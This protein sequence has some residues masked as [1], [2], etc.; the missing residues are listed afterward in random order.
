[1]IRFNA[2]YY[3]KTESA[4]VAAAL[5]GEDFLP[6]AKAH[7]SR[8]YGTNSLFL[9]SSGGTALDLLLC[10]LDLPQGQRAILPSFTFP[11]DANAVLRAGL[12]PLFADIDA[13]NTL[14]IGDVS[15]KITP[16]TACV[17]PTH[18]GGASVDMDTLKS[19]I[20][21]A[22]LIEDAALSF[23]AS[24]KNRPLGTVGDMGIVSFHRTKN[25]SSEEGGM[26]IVNHADAALLEKIQT[27]YDNGTD[28]QAFLR[29]DVPAYTWQSSGMN[30][31]MSN[32]SAAVLCAQL[33]KADE[34]ACRR[35]AVYDAYL[36]A[37]KHT[38]GITLP[39]VPAY[40]T[41]NHHVFY[42][43]L[44]DAQ[45]RDR[46]LRQLNERGIGACFHYMPLHTSAMGQR[47]GC[48]PADLPVTVDISARILRLPLHACMTPRDAEYAAT[49]LK[50]V[51]CGQ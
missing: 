30:G 26:L 18:Y 51:L 27:I 44:N 10:A 39:H 36:A 34:I 4:N 23:G 49:A 7:L 17:I 22:L 40:N 45:I 50:E 29:G 15:A 3:D 11:S 25:I 48:R 28:K 47:L 43:L 32:L 6:Q 21:N 46:V 8:I 33:D 9:T 2:P 35:K 37:L 24:Y 16:D 14:N 5:G 13:T 19:H 31:A 20:G 1:M 42:V 41:D 12:V 38:P